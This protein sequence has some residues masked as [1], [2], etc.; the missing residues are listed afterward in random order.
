MHVIQAWSCATVLLSNTKNISSWSS[1]WPLVG[2]CASSR[3]GTTKLDDQRGGSTTRG[4]STAPHALSLSPGA[5]AHCTSAVAPPRASSA[6]STPRPLA[7]P[8]WAASRF[9]VVNAS[10]AGAAAKAFIS[11]SRHVISVCKRYSSPRRYADTSPRTSAC[12][13]SRSRQTDSWHDYKKVAFAVVWRDDWPS[14]AAARIRLSEA[15][16]YPAVELSGVVRCGGSPSG[17]GGGTS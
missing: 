5:P 13:N 17:G 6:T 16:E 1:P 11:A 7:G 4:G 3:R 10:A 9:V 14:R 15:A 12:R 2:G 8:A